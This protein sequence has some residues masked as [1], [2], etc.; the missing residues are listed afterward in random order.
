MTIY[1]V[2]TEDSS[3]Y[4]TQLLTIPRLKGTKYLQSMML[5]SLTAMLSSIKEL[6]HAVD[7][8]ATPFQFDQW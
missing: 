3:C 5:W 8:I 1:I 2:Q 7:D 4:G 6:W